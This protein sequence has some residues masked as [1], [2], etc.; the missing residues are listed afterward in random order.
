M[1][2]LKFGVSECRREAPESPSTCGAQYLPISHVNTLCL[3]NQDLQSVFNCQLDQSYIHLQE[4]Y[5]EYSRLQLITT[6]HYFTTWIYKKHNFFK[7][8]S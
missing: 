3:C 6:S 7:K 1:F 5:L 8:I 2:K 4:I